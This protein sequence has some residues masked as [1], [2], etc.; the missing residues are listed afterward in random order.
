MHGKKQFSSFASYN[1]CNK[2]SAYESIQR[3]IRQQK[4]GWR[5]KGLKYGVS[6]TYSYNAVHIYDL[7]LPSQ[8]GSQVVIGSEQIIR[9]RVFKFSARV[10]SS[11]EQA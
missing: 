2:N 6:R 9:I 11:F 5:F 3:S 10:I 7:S 1:S 4:V 8:C